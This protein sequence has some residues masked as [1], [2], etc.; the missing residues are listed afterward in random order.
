MRKLFQLLGLTNEQQTQSPKKKGSEFGVSGSDENKQSYGENNINQEEP[1]QKPDFNNLDEEFA[2]N[3]TR[4]GGKFMFCLSKKSLLQTLAHVLKD[5]NWNKVFV[6][7]SEI[8]TL[9]GEDIKEITDAKT[10]SHV[11]ADVFISTCDNLVA[12]NGR[13]MVSSNQCKNLNFSEL[14]VNHIIIAN[15]SQIVKNLGEG[16]RR[17]NAKYFRNLP[18]KITTLKNK[19]T[20]RNS[21]TSKNIYVF[22]LEDY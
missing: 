3:F 18:S 4:E 1:D 20:A 6:N 9:L 2:Y 13:I 7:E 16:L 22:L 14:P 15:H 12:F 5:E 8:D 17:I 19:N 21:G 11:G 10:T